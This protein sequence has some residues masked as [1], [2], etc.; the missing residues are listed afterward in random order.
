MAKLELNEIFAP[1]IPSFLPSHDCSLHTTKGAAAGAAGIEVLPTT[2]L[3]TPPDSRFPAPVP[4]LVTRWSKQLLQN[5][6]L[7]HT[8]CEWSSCLQRERNRKGKFWRYK[9]EEME[10]NQ[11][12]ATLRRLSLF[13]IIQISKKEVPS[14][15]QGLSHYE[16]L[17]LPA[18][19]ESFFNPIRFW[20]MIFDLKHCLN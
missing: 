8:T 18:Y 20:Q 5:K 6:S 10:E 15:P 9:L 13:K 4:T 16:V 11:T 12:F 2:T 1:S 17:C 7:V 14:Y 3:P 19:L